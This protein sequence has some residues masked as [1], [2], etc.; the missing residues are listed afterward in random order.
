MMRF[1]SYFNTTI[2]ILE[3]YD[4]KMPLHHFLKQYFAQ[5]KKHGS[6]DRKI[7]SHACYNFFRTGQALKN[8]SIE[9]KLKA[10]VF[11]C[12]AGS[13]GW[14]FLFDAEWIKNRQETL[15]KRIAFVENKLPAF[16]IGHIFPFADELS[17]SVE[18][19][20]FIQSFFVQPD[21][22][23]RMRPGKKDIVISKLEE[24][25]IPYT[26]LDDRAAS[27]S[28]SV[29]ID[30]VIHP[31]EEA[32]IQDYSS[33]QLSIFFENIKS[34][35]AGDHKNFEV[36]DCCAASGGKSILAKDILENIHL[37]VSDLRSSIIHNLKQR[38]AKAGIRKYKSF[39]ADVT[40]MQP[41]DRF[42]LIICDA[43][44]TGSGTWS[45][46]PEQLYF[47]QQEKIDSF[48]A[49]Q[50]NIVHSIIPALRSSGY[51]LYITC[52]VFE[53]ENEA[54]VKFIQ[55]ELQLSLLR[56]ELLKGYDKKADTMFVALFKKINDL[57]E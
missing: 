48:S 49:L 26:L 13:D 44:C 9:D 15:Q 33:Q 19:Q 8:N 2:Q 37:T 42:D 16:S 25:K 23:I 28:P 31:D 45:R 12:N 17:P 24:Q 10:A 46:T 27:F 50:K 20:Q 57:P 52:S 34:V 11:I 36:W 53:K 38:F 3:A 6:T 56:M 41:S 39:V 55:Q 22:F 14:D 21:V 7:I 32:V 54:I 4:G 51:L 1:Q 47:F 18:T 35:T 29:K 30:A 43:P 40:A 5:H